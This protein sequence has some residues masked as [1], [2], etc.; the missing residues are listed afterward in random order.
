MAQTDLDICN[1]AIGRAGGEKIASLEENSPLAQF[2]AQEYPQKRAF[3][4]GMYRWVFANKVAPLTR[5]AVKPDGCPLAYGFARPVN[6]IG[7]IHDFRTGQDARSDKVAAIQ[8]ADFV[9]ADEATVYAEYTA[10]VHES[11]WPSWFEELAIT[12]FAVDICGQVGKRGQAD[13]LMIK[14]FGSPEMA[15]AG[16]LCLVAMQA[17]SRN[18]PQRTLAYEGGGELLNARYGVGL[19][20]PSGLR[21]VGVSTGS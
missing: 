11:T 1:R 3:L 10:N 9:A 18:A 8:M 6:I 4:L 15:G 16:G 19:P 13:S 14:A 7:A 5:L 2:C 20:G 21:F 12:A 17:D